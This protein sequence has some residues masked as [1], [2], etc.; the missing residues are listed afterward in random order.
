[1]ESFSTALA[2]MTTKPAPMPRIGPNCIAAEIVTL[3]AHS[4]VAHGWLSCIHW[5]DATVAV[6]R[7]KTTTT[8]SSTATHMARRPNPWR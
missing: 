7:T 1:M 3:V 8:T 2:A 6:D 5:S 4:V